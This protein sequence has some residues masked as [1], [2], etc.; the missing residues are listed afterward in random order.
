LIARVATRLG[1]ATRETIRSWRSSATFSSSS[2]CWASSDRQPLPAPGSLHLRPPLPDTARWRLFVAAPLPEIAAARAF[3]ALAP[4]RTLHPQVKWLPLNK[5]HLTLVFLGQT[6]S[7]RVPEIAAKVA[8]VAESRQKFDVVTGEAG[9]KLGGD[10]GGVCWLRL[11]RGGHEVAQLSLD[12]DGAV[13]SHTYNSN[14]GPRPHL[15]V[16]RHVT[17]ATLEDLRRLSAEVTLDWT[18]DRITLFR[19]HTDPGGSRYEELSSA[20]LGNGS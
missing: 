17:A 10:R 5:L 15:T 7:D 16:A 18:V 2:T 14:T 9:G 8:A 19:S 1:C 13:A 12:V 20:K 3:E 11:A 4:I 6:D